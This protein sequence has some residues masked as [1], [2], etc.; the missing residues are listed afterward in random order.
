MA[1]PDFQDL[2]LPLLGV[3]ADGREHVMRDVIAALA[4][5]LQLTPEERAERV[6]TNQ[7]DSVVGNRASWAKSHLKRAGLLINPGRGR[8]VI[9]ELGRQVLARKPARINSQF[10]AQFPTYLS[11]ISRGNDEPPSSIQVSPSSVAQQKTPLELI[12]ASYNDLKQATSE[13]LLSRIKSVSPG[14]FEQLVLDVLL[15]M[16]YGGPGR[17]GWR[18]GKTGDGGIDGIIWQDKLGL[19]IVCVQA[20]RWEGTVGRPVVM[21]FVGSMDH[22]RAKK[23]IIVTTSTFTKDAC[24]FVE[25]VEGKKVVL[26]DGIKLSKLMIEY[27]VGVAV[28]KTYELKEVS[29]DY[30]DE[31]EA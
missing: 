20:K 31:D 16:G 3:L 13:D 15:A 17:D 12:E 18:T 21:G 22:V 11:F 23:G 27:N 25:R 4:D 6:S 26:V 28:T 14:R 10:L 29:N 19:D 2:M 9:S 30:F 7:H 8:V 5:R 24:E 1:I